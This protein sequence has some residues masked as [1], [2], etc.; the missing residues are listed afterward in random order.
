M[1]LCRFIN[2][3]QEAYA[4]FM[5]IYAFNFLK[6]A[7]AKAQSNTPADFNDLFQNA[8]TNKLKIKQSVD[9]K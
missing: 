4:F 1:S 2:S 6:F 9:V 8:E 7:I 3:Y 5:E